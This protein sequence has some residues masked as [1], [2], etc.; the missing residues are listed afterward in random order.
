M[1]FV[2]R[3]QGSSIIHGRTSLSVKRGS[4]ADRIKSSWMCLHFEKKREKKR[5]DG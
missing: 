3:N 1:Q 5:A 2:Q 4:V